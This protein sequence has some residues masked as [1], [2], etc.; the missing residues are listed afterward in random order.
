MRLIHKPKGK[1]KN[2]LPPTTKNKTAFAWLQKWLKREVNQCNRSVTIR[3]V[4]LH[5]CNATRT[6]AR[7]TVRVHAIRSISVV[8]RFD[9]S[10]HRVRIRCPRRVNYS[11]EP[12]VTSAVPDIYFCATSCLMASD[13]LCSPSGGVL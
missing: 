3:E 8:V 7:L 9:P 13:P 5:K 10:G 4:Q 2:P 12:I 1:E 11:P 6:H